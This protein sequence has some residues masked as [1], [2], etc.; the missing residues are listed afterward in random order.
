MSRRATKLFTALFFLFFSLNM[1]AEESNTTFSVTLGQDP[2]FGFYPSV[3]G[4][5]GISDNSQFTFYGVF[6]TQDALAGYAGGLNL[7]TEWGAGVN[8]TLLD[9]AL[10][11]NP[12]L[13]LA[14]GNFQSGGGRPVIADNIVPSLYIIYTKDNFFLNISG[15]YW[16]S[17]R[18]EAKVTPLIDLLDYSFQTGF[19]LGKYFSLGLYYDHL[20]YTEDNSNQISSG[21]RETVTSY[22]WIGPIVGIQ[23]KENASVM[24]SFGADLVEQFNDNIPSNAKKI[25]DYYKLTTSFGF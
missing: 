23:F 12:S 3:A 7:L 24:F 20:F 18:N 10:N 22:L 11:I 21:K 9:G 16:K 5:I 6:W 17:F 15:I 13:G 2:A 25:N 1:Q 8:F 4:S 14:H 19:S